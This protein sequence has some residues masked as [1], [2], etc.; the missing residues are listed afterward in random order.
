[1]EAY[2]VRRLGSS[3][4]LSTGCVRLNMRRSIREDVRYVAFFRGA[5]QNSQDR[6]P[7]AP[8]FK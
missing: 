3:E 2:M 4:G 1:V 8:L 7:G 6:D 5:R